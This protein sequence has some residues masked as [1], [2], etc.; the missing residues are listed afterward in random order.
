[1]SSCGGCG[2]G[3]ESLLVGPVFT[4]ADGDCMSG[5][6]TGITVTGGAEVK[7]CSVGS[8]GL[9]AVKVG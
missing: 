6:G 8:V 3:D 4:V 2:E 7:E 5:G 9:G 1:M